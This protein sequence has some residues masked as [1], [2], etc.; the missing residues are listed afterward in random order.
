MLNVFSSS[1][2]STS[3]NFRPVPDHQEVFVEQETDRSVIF[4]ILEMVNAENNE[5]AALFHWNELVQCNEAVN[6]RIISSG[7]SK[8]SL[9]RVM[10]KF[11]VLT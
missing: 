4:E 2:V 7:F 6:A 1:H 10:K 8:L 5:K 11:N 3:S 9:N